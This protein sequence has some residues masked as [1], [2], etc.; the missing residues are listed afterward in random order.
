[1]FYYG[2]VV[3]GSPLKSVMIT[4]DAPLVVMT[5]YPQMWSKSLGDFDFLPPKVCVG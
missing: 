4:G 2:N 1:M 3:K 5:F